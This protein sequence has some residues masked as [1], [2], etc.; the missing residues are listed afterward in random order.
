MHIQFI[1]LVVA[2][3]LLSPVYSAAIVPT[4]VRHRGI[5]VNLEALGNSQVRVTVSNNAD[6]EISV[7]KMNSFFDESPIQKVNVYRDDDSKEEVLFK[8]IQPRYDLTHLTPK[9]F[10]SLAPGS[11][12]TSEF[13]IADTLDLSPGGNYT[14]SSQG[15]FLVGRDTNS[16][17]ITGV[18]PYKSNTIKVSIDAASIANRTRSRLLSHSFTT[19]APRTQLDSDSCTGTQ[20][21]EALQTALQNTV[22]LSLRA[23][24]AARYGD[25]RRFEEYFRTTSESVRQDVSSRFLAIAVEASSSSSSSSSPSRSSTTY[26]CTDPL[27]YCN[28]NTLAYAIPSRSVI[29]N[30]PLYYR[31]PDLTTRCHGQDQATTTLHELTHAERVYSPHTVDHAYGYEAS[32]ALDAE[33]AVLNADTYALFANALEIGC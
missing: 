13:D 7:L 12:I 29:V 31:L 28:S 32:R 10:A 1:F 30:C 25:Q 2:A 19:L 4:G 6:H 26:F 16:S 24:R 15:V 27:G 9:N 17:S 18:A 33:E 3:V 21:G 11:N 14:I 20:E 5:E 23:A 8:G 22:S